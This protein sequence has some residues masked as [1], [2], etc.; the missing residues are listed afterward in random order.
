[1]AQAVEVGCVFLQSGDAC[2]GHH[3]ASRL[4]RARA[5]E[6]ARLPKLGVQAQGDG[7]ADQ[8]EGG[9]AVLSLH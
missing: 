8:Q 5:V 4:D 7:H 2:G 9:A 1:M 3:S 6:E